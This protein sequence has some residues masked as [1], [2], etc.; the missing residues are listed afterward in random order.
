LVV[1]EASRVSIKAPFEG[2]SEGI[3]TSH[4]SAIR[5]LLATDLV[6]LNHGQVMRTT[7]KLAPPSPNY[8]YTP[9][10]LHL[11]SQQI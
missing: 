7:L 8:P 3:L 1:P 11:S 5:G 2:V 9:T 4:C 6:I 10:G